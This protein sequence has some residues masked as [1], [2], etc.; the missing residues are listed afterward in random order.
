MRLAFIPFNSYYD[1]ENKTCESLDH[2][3]FVIDRIVVIK[4]VFI[5]KIELIYD[6][7]LLFSL[8]SKYIPFFRLIQIT[9]HPFLFS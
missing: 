6:C 1:C 3:S 7:I 2:Y 8:I 9:F 5:S 4:I